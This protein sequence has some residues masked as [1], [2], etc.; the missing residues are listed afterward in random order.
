[1]VRIL[2]WREL[3]IGVKRLAIFLGAALL[4]NQATA[5]ANRTCCLVRTRVLADGCV[6]GSGASGEGSDICSCLAA[7][8]TQGDST[9]HSGQHESGMHMSMTGP[10]GPYPMSRESSGTSWQPDSAK[11]QG[12]HLMK[13]DWMLMLHGFAQIV[14]DHQGGKRGDSKTYSANMFRFV[15]THELGRGTFAFR[16]MVSADPLT[17]GREGYPLLFET[18]ETADGRTPLID[19]QHPHDLF[20]EIAVSYSHPFAESTSVFAYFGLPGEPALGPPVYM[21]RFSAEEIPAAPLTHHWLDSTHI[22]YGV[23]TVGVTRH[24]VKLEASLFNGREPDQYRYDIESPKFD[25]YAFRASYN[26]AS[27]W[28]FQASF[29][30]LRSPEQLEPNVAQERSTASAI[31]NRYWNGNQWQTTLA[32]GQNV[33]KPGH[34]LNG[35]LLESTV[36]LKDTHTVFGRLERVRKDELFLPGQPLA[37]SI[38]TVGEGSLGYIYDFYHGMHLKA[39]LGAMGSVDVVPGGLKSAYGNAPLSALLFLR[40]KLK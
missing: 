12:I 7:G 15:G 37:G 20:M 36:A 6:G 38:F 32:W 19:R 5:L 29:G 25:S 16:T 40:L 33:N 14:Y 17:I 8:I 22:S 35:V 39:G 26:P 11:H 23:A 10:L 21:H 13:D 28:A 4:V 34:A 3:A 27:N 30:R 9:R 31:Y 18:G 1:M 24:A 2:R